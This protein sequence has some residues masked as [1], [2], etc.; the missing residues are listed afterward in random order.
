[1]IGIG[2]WK[3]QLAEHKCSHRAVEQEIVPLDRGAD[4]ARDD[5]TSQLRAM[6]LGR[7]GGQAIVGCHGPPSVW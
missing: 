5:R 1:M 3:E 4:S 2:L 7:Q 6:L